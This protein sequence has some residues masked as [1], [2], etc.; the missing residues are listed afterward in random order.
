MDEAIRQRLTETQAKYSEM[1]MAK[2]NVIGVGLGYAQVDG[3]LTDVPAIVVLVEV[4]LP[5]AALQSEDIIPRELDEMR[6]DVQ[7]TGALNAF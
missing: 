5:L 7:E 6:V 2:A 1:L 3:E 4:K